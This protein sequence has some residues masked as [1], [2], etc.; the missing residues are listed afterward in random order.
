MQAPATTPSPTPPHPM[1]ATE[2][3]GPT[4]P[5]LTAAPTPAIT[6]QPSNP[7]TD[8]RAAGS[9]QVRFSNVRRMTQ[10]I[11]DA[12]IAAAGLTGRWLAADF[13]VT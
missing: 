13:R 6:P 12:A 8:G 10:E 4:S 2:A 11:I 1:T 5:V 3:R 7:T 9:E